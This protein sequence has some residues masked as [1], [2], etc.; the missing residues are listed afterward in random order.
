MAGRITLSQPR[1]GFRAGFD[2]V[3]LGAAV[4]AGTEGLLDLGAGVGTAGL[5]ALAMERARHATLVERHGETAALAHDNVASN[6]FVGRAEVLVLD[7]LAPGS[8]RNAAGLRANHFQTVIANPPFFEAG[9]GTLAPETSRA[10]ARHMAQEG[11]DAWV[12]CAAGCAAGGGELIVV[13]PAQGLTALLNAM[14]ARFG[15]ITVLPISPRAGQAATRILVRGIKG[16]RA[17]LTLL[18]GRALHGESGR[19]FMPEFDAIFR[20]VA[21]LDW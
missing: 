3:L 8:V 12:K 10:D 17:P 14:T 16:S 19:D 9:Q 5:V 2:S 15:A 6:G 21:A 13:Y 20:G 4:R 7:I 18:A 11:L 1:N